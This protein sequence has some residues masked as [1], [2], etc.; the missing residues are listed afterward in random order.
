MLLYIKSGGQVLNALIRRRKA[1]R[2]LFLTPSD[3]EDKIPSP[4]IK[5]GSKGIDVKDLQEYLMDKGYYIGSIDSIFGNMLERAVILFQYDTGLVVDGIVGAKTWAKVKENPGLKT[6]VFSLVKDGD[7][8][9]SENFKISEFRC[10][11]G[12]D[13]ILINA[14]FVQ[15]KLQEIRNYFAAAITINSG[16][17][18]IAY[19]RRVNGASSSYHL[20]GRA[21]DIV[22]K[23]H[24]PAEVAMYAQ[25]LGITGI[26][27]YNTFVHIDSRPERYWVRNNN[28][29]VSSLQ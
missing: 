13:R 23:G 20:Y 10:K 7:K 12:A 19:N 9:I 14:D 22:V 1:E 4:L 24:T 6:K 5:K 25:L 27:Q 21:F 26:I 17:R 29:V 16:F 11:D 3:N 2:E 8:Y 18:T 28:G 15:C